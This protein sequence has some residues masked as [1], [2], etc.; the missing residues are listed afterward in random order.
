MQ[1]R[2][3]QLP[4]AMITNYFTLAA[5]TIRRSTSY[6]LVNVLGLTFGITCAIIIFSLVRYHLSFDTF[7]NDSDRIYRFVTE[8]H[9]DD[10]EYESSVPPAFGKAF[11]ED[12]TYA[13]KVARICVAN[14]LLSFEDKGATHKFQ[15][16]IAFADASY[17]EL[18]NFPLASGVN[19]LDQPGTAVITE[20]VARKFFG[21]ES[22]LGKVIRFENKSDFRILGT[23]ADLPGNTDLRSEILLSYSNVNEHSKWYAADDA[24]GGITSSIKTYARMR[25]G[26]DPGEVE[27]HLA[28]YVKKYRA[29]ASNVHHYKLQPLADVHFS[30]LYNGAISKTILWVL[31][32]IGFFLVLTACLNFVNLATAQS[33]SRSREVGVRKALGG[34]R[35]QLFWQFTLETGV[36][37]FLAFFVSLALATA[38]IPM[39]NELLE[40]KININLADGTLWIFMALL[41]VAVTFMAGAYPGMVLSGFRPVQALKGIQAGAETLNIRRV[42]ITTQ[43]SIT[44][45]LLI[46]LIV[47]LSQVSYFHNTELGYERKAVVMIPM[48]SHDEKSKTLK[49]QFL[50]LPNV[51][52][53]TLCYSAPAAPYSW[54]TSFGYDHRQEDEPFGSRFQAGDEDYLNTFKI[55]L[56]AGRN[57]LPSDTIKEFL[58]N[59]TFVAKLGET[60]ESVLGKNIAFND[61]YNGNIVG[62]LADYHDESLH[63]TINPVMMTTSLHYSS[64]YAVKINMSEAGSTLEALDK[65]WSAMYPEQLYA[66]DF[67]DDQTAK[68]YKTEDTMLGVIEVFAFIALIV[69]CIGLYGLASFMASRKT[70]E[71]GIRK[72]LGGSIQHILWLFGREFGLLVLLAFLVAAPVSG[73]LMTSWL[74]NYPN[75]IDMGAWIFAADLLIV[76]VVVLIT[77]GFRTLK[78]ATMNP[79]GALRTE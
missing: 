70:K 22:A 2:Y 78:A 59:E 44:H 72:V 77:V 79:A 4:S 16:D 61:R 32:I 15:E 42:L 9:R 62:V 73:M 3:Q 19:E 18:F 8:E 30:P 57:L 34:L 38:L 24:W 55:D 74:S 7:H 46:G 58:V 37:V 45:M 23:M 66:Y 20:R 48:G 21:D 13:E 6:T 54:E 60:N 31:S 28:D 52:H 41:I 64:V 10:V 35:T 65:T 5:R 43:F 71:I 27:K 49:E 50:R 68:F 76:V 36:I 40:T 1:F 63:T 47:V 11:R 14:S 53:V 56:V 39:V 29:G 17:L 69:G 12:Y 51:E 33:V 75:R 26:V 67:L 25:P